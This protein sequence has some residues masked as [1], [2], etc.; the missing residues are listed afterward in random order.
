MNSNNC[1][2]FLFYLKKSCKM[3]PKSKIFHI[4][5]PLSKFHFFTFSTLSFFLAAEFPPFSARIAA[6]IQTV[7]YSVLPALHLCTQEMVL[8]GWKKCA[9]M[10]L[11]FNCPAVKRVFS[12]LFLICKEK[13]CRGACCKF[14][15]FDVLV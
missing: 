13:A 15:M 3:Q 11:V 12:L 1:A 8:T 4:I 9:I 2:G 5:S 10:L 6:K 14:Y 7:L